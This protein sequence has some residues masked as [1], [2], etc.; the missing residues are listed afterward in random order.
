[1]PSIKAVTV[2]PVVNYFGL[3]FL[4]LKEASCLAFHHALW[5]VLNLIIRFQHVLFDRGNDL[6]AYE[7]TTPVAEGLCLFYK[8][9]RV[10]V[11]CLIIMKASDALM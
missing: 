1:M 5:F 8:Q 2:F 3:L 9:L 6:Y 7:H 4:F 11:V 10:F